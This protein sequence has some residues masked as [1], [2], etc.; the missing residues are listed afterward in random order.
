METSWPRRRIKV[1]GE[2]C[3]FRMLC[4][5]CMV[6]R[7]AE[8]RIRGVCLF[9]ESQVFVCRIEVSFVLIA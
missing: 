3:E 6:C 1:V 5:V 7:T 9:A 2:F 4:G 8:S